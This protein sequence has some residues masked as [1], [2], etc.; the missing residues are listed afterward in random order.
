MTNFFRLKWAVFDPDA[1]G[2]IVIEDFKKLMFELG[3]PLGWDENFPIQ[4]QKHFQAQMKLK[5]YR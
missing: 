2:F 3:E 1:T 4:Q 5:T